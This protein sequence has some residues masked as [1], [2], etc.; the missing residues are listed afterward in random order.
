MVAPVQSIRREPQQTILSRDLA[1]YIERVTELAPAVIYVYNQDLKRN[2]YSN[3]DIGEVLGYTA[4]EIKD[5]GENLMAQTLHADDLPLI[6]EHFKSIGA[7]TDGEVASVEYRMRHKNG[8]WVWLLSRDAV[9]KR[10]QTGRVTHHIGAAIDITAQKNAEEAARKAQE[11]TNAVNGELRDFAYA[12]S[13]DMKAPSNTLHLILDELVSDSNRTFEEEESNLLDLAQSTVS[14]MGT[15]IDDVLR[16][17]KIIG[18]DLELETV[19]LTTLIAE[20]RETLHAEIKMS[21]A[22]IWVSDLPAVRG[23]RMQLAILFQ[24]LIQNAL[25]FSRPGIA[26]IVHIGAE[27]LEN[28]EAVSIYVSDNGIGIPPDKQEQI[29]HVFKRLNVTQKYEGNGIGLATCR[30]IASNHKT[31]ISLVSSIGEGAAFSVHLQKA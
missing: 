12:V 9:F 11:E 8:G 10:D 5:M 14:R 13:H 3:R 16:Y 25:K 28:D 4:R 20:L 7:L 23:S 17:T 18:Q 26:P 6:L 27:K 24:N 29:F 21:Q 2:E 15:L 1:P 19:D 31:N 22:T 30:R